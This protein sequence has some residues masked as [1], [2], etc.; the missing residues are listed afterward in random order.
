MSEENNKKKISI[1]EIAK[2]TT[3]A[4]KQAAKDAKTFV[5]EKAAHT[6]VQA[7]KEIKDYTETKVIPAVKETTNKTKTAV[8]N[9][10]KKIAD[11][12]EEVLTEE[13]VQEI[14]NMLY[15]K[16]INGIPK[17]SLP[18][19]D[20][21]DD[22]MKKNADVE[23]AI[24]SLIKNSTIKCGTSGFLT[25]LGG[26]T[27][28][29][30][31]LPA[32]ITSVLYVQLRMSCAIAKIGGYDIHSD[33]VQTMIFACLTG[34]A[35]T[36]ILKQ[37]GIKFG[38][39]FT[40]AMIKKIPA[41]VLTKI[42]KAV[43]F[44]FLTKFGTKGIINLGKLVPVLGGIIGGGVDVASTVTIGNNAYKVFVKNEMP[45]G[46]KDDLIIEADFTEKIEDI[47]DLMLSAIS[48][49]DCNEKEKLLDEEKIED[50][51]RKVNNLHD[52]GLI[53][54]ETFNNKIRE[55]ISEI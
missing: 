27:T 6:I 28:I 26:F 31:T 36:D 37:A 1:K 18:I 9:T 3:S 30:A 10:A 34:S 15:I 19:E 52:Q 51:I 49:E 40:T 2:K 16:S 48:E 13:K 38:T 29:I 5:S 42:N 24:K 4:A 25:S 55:L 47:D 35:M 50:R 23:S 54:D 44:R 17:V 33:Q 7:G 21:V 32:N 53:D 12:K 39:K 46:E 11:K 43:G 8:K 41:A 45:T 22:Y 20:L 14:L